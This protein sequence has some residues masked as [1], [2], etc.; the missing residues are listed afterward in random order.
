MPSDISDAITQDQIAESLLGNPTEQQGD[1]KQDTGTTD[2]FE[3]QSQNQ[4]VA[5]AEE[6]QQAQEDDENWLPNE[7]EKVFPFD[8]VAKYAQRYGY[9]PEEIQA[10]P[11]LQ[12]TLTERLN[13][14]IYVNQ[15]RQ[16]QSVQ[17]EDEPVEQQR[18]EPT[19]PQLSTQEFIQQL[20]RTAEGFVDQDIA[21]AFTD[22]FLKVW[23]AN[24]TAT[25][26]QSRNFTRVMTTFGLNLLN[27]VLPQLM[28]A[29]MSES[30][31]FFQSLMDQNYEGFK[32]GF[33]VQMYDRAWAKAANSIPQLSGK[34]LSQVGDKLQEAAVRFAG[35]AEEFEAMQFKGK[36]GK[37][38]SPYQNTVKKYSILA[39]MVSG[40]KLTVNEAKSFVEA[41]RKA[42]RTAQVR[43]DAS[44]IGSGKSAGQIS[45]KAS[46]QKYQTNSDIFDDESEALWQKM[47][48]RI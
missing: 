14:D 3:D 2:Q 18:T 12:R 30:Q 27:T 24:N 38:L 28:N 32:D 37:P 5:E 23:G 43:R 6:Q 8:T 33:E 48:G 10:D 15:L 9:S 40:E 25:P 16:R 19:R 4:D 36:D 39:K 11:R 47:H 34:S 35:S 31:T 42:E 22:Q 1:Q 46:S 45:G 20:N 21:N 13:Q 44:S 29:R 41:G 26:E 7:Q 17:E